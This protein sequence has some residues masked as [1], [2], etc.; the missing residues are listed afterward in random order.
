MIEATTR[1]WSAIIAAISVL[2]VGD[3]L[4]FIISSLVHLGAP[5][6]LGF[7]EPVI[8]PASIVEGLCGIFLTVGVYALFTRRAWTWRMAISAHIFAIAG[9]L[10]GIFATSRGGGTEANFIYHRAILAALVLTLI[11]LLIPG[12]R[13]ALDRSK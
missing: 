5:I 11:L 7:S 2:M 9:V 3:A 12:T 1:R 6:P 4:T 13:A 8:I 10:L